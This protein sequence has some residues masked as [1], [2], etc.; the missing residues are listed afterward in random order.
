MPEM[1][2]M[3]ERVVARFTGGLRLQNA[4]KG[5]K[6]RRIFSGRA[7]SL[8]AGSPVVAYGGVYV[9]TA[10]LQYLAFLALVLS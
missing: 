7:Y 5:R 4:I 3:G 2:D 1:G 6:E 10:L 9:G 8:L